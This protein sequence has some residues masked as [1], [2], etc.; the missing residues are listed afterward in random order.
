MESGPACRV[1]RRAASA[2]ISD[3][4]EPADQNRCLSGDVR[5]LHGLPRGFWPNVKEV[6]S[7]SGQSPL[8][9]TEQ[10]R[11]LGSE[12]TGRRRLTFSSIQF[13]CRAHFHKLQI[14]LRVLYNLH[15]D[16]PDL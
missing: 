4:W 12:P 14:P 10:G 9:R 2:L 11:L 13:I 3:Q 6:E 1:T 15:I 16:I 8:V 7:G 5:R